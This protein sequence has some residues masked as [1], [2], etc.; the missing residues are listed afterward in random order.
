MGRLRYLVLGPLLVNGTEG[1][2]SPGGVKTRSVLADLLLHPNQAVSSDRLVN[3][4]W[5]EQAWDMD[6]HVLHSHITR[7]RAVVGKEAIVQIDGSYT[8]VA[9]PDEI[10]AAA[11]EAMVHSAISAEDPESTAQ[12]CVAAIGLWRGR[13]FGDLADAEFLDLEVRRLEE[14]RLEALE[15]WFA[16]ELELGR[17]REIIGNLRTAVDEHPY[18]ERL[19]R[20]YLSALRAS[21]RHAEALI[22][23]TELERLLRDELDIEPPQDLRTLRDSIASD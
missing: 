16:A 12:Q 13:P 5:G 11:F 4:V 19:W 9:E 6:P 21:G 8:L 3:D 7:L 22:A 1:P 15:A 2:V 20:C 14:V 17:H 18:D 10:D 23:Y